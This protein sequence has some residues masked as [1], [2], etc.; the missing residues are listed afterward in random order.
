VFSR[1][2]RE[3]DVKVTKPRLHKHAWSSCI[4]PNGSKMTPDDKSLAT[5]RR[6]LFEMLTY[7]AARHACRDTHARLP[8]HG[9]IESQ[10]S[11][12]LSR[13]VRRILAEEGALV[14]QDDWVT[15]C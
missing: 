11:L 9:R 10:K 13:R 2:L 1:L 12:S 7:P 3:K 8:A 5:S 4:R 15:F 14:F 6:T